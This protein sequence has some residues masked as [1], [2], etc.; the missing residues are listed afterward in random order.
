M[1]KKYQQSQGL[2]GL[3]AAK[4]FQIQVADVLRDF[5]YGDN[6]ETPSGFSYQ[7]KG[8][9]HLCIEVPHVLG[10]CVDVVLEKNGDSE[11]P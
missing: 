3:Y 8:Q 5:D 10:D 2:L 7:E 9:T 4:Q 6:R 11:Q 1:T